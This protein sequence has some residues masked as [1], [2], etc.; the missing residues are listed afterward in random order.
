MWRSEIGQQV[1]L[2]MLLCPLAI[3]NDKALNQL[4]GLSTFE[5]LDWY[6][7]PSNTE[8]MAA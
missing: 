8:Q 3:C 6:R 2:Y 1:L 7:L 5:W 4:T